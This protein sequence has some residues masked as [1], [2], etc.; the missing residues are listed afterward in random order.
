MF[1]LRN[2]TCPTCKGVMSPVEWKA[3][4]CLG[5]NPFKGQDGT[6]TKVTGH[7]MVGATGDGRAHPERRPMTEAE[8]RLV[9]AA[10]AWRAQNGE[11]Y[12]KG[13]TSD[14]LCIWIRAVV[15][16]RN[17]P[18]PRPITPEELAVI[19]VAKVVARRIDD[20]GRAGV[21]G[22][23]KDDSK[24]LCDAVRRLK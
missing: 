10:I 8:E 13:T 12:D 5:G 21:Y 22:S 4:L 24:A 23:I 6:A 2:V 17:P 1:E 16:E 20:E 3:H 15:N 14:N 9:E 7:A 18:P 11:V 19:E